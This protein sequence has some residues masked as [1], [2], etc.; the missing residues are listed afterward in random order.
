MLIRRPLGGLRTA[1]GAGRE[2]FERECLHVLR[3]QPGYA[4]EVVACGAEEKPE[5]VPRDAEV[6]QLSAPDAS[7][8]TST[9]SAMSAAHPARIPGHQLNNEHR[10]VDAKD[11]QQHSA[12]G[13]ERAELCELRLLA[14]A[15]VVDETPGQPP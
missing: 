15:T 6:S 7:P 12:L 11:G 13:I 2:R 14:G 3:G 8:S 9:E 4:D 5:L 1:E 10:C